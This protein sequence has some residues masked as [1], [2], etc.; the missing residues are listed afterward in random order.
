MAQRSIKGTVRLKL[1]LSLKPCSHSDEKL[2]I[3]ANFKENNEYT[4]KRR[5]P[6]CHCYREESYPGF[7]VLLNEYTVGKI[8]EP[9]FNTTPLLLDYKK[10]FNLHIIKTPLLLGIREY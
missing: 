7:F 1:R 2:S 5:S 4:L 10:T 8:S 6:V 3:F 9:P